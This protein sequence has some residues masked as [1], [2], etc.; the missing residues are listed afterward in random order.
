M[1]ERK[2]PEKNVVMSCRV[3]GKLRCPIKLL[4]EVDLWNKGCSIWGSTC[5]GTK[6]LQVVRKMGYKWYAPALVL[7]SSAKLTF[8]LIGFFRGGDKVRSQRVQ[9]DKR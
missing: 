1:K 7:V 3:H 9:G 4:F 5:G 2:T 8:V 6:I